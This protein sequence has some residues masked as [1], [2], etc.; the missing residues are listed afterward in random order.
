MKIT[1]N[2][3]FPLSAL[4]LSL[5]ACS[6]SLNWNEHVGPSEAPPSGEGC[7]TNEIVDDF[8][9]S[10]PLAAARSVI[11]DA[12]GNVYVAGWASASST[13]HSRWVVRKSSDQGSTWRT[14]DDYQV[15]E[16]DNT[17]AFALA[18][19]STGSIY[20]GGGTNTVSRANQ[21][22]LRMSFNGGEEWMLFSNSLAPNSH[23]EELAA[24]TVSSV[25]NLF[26]GIYR[27]G[28]AGERAWYVSKGTE[29]S[30]VDE[31]V[32]RTSTYSEG[33]VISM[34]SDPVGNVYAIGHV[35]HGW[36]YHWTV[37]KSADQG[38]SWDTVDDFNGGLVKAGASDSQGNLYVTGLGDT[39]K[40]GGWITRKSTDAGATWS[41]IDV[42]QY[43]PTHTNGPA[44][45]SVSATGTIVVAG[46]ASDAAWNTR[47]IVR[48]SRDQGAT[49]EVL[50][51]QVIGG[52][53][54]G[55]PH[56]VWIAPDETI[57]T[58]GQA[59][60]RWVTRKITNCRL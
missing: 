30:L 56:G 9:L 22:I 20:V 42:F 4:F 1:E 7:A 46:E 23:V 21:H 49:W 13:S 34:F 54:G 31:F 14:V 52:A 38:V 59:R 45:I 25:G 17:A 44:A 48:Q 11:G 19:S 29:L 40:G 53:T 51:D 50:D 35:R 15:S 5:A 8:S 2:S 43:L 6:P 26:S 32:H 37:R 24:L 36:G 28:Q 47:W 10:G 39:S 12:A 3:V 27:L 33:Q 58:V 57:Y 55:F 41:T 18:V 16:Q 60:N